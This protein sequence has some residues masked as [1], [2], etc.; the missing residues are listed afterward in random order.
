[1]QNT[2]LVL[3]IGL[4]LPNFDRYLTHMFRIEYFG[5]LCR[6]FIVCSKC[7]NCGT[8]ICSGLLVYRIFKGT[9]D[10]NMIKNRAPYIIMLVKKQER[11]TTW[12][13][14]Y[15]HIS[16]QDVITL[17]LTSTTVW[18]R[19]VPMLWSVCTSKMLHNVIDVCEMSS[20]LY[21]QKKSHVYL[22]WTFYFYRR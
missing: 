8:A 5:K 18:F 14:I 3:I 7:F 11:I 6:Y 21:H 19:F 2:P 22:K 1:M 4:R 17:A 16:L 13:R 12:I 10:K 20:N 9:C 15:I